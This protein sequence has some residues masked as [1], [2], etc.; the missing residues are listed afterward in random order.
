M[1]AVNVIRY[2]TIL[3]F[4]ENGPLDV[5]SIVENLDGKYSKNQILSTLQRMQEKD[6]VK[7]KKNIV[8][9]KKDAFYHEN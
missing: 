5:D 1:K 3:D 8:T 6:Y 2:S 9:K 7:I 4:L